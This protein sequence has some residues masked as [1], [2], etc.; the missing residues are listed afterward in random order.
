MISMIRLVLALGFVGA[1]TYAQ[2]DVELATARMVGASQVAPVFFDPGKN[3]LS[4]EEKKELRTFFTSLRESEK[5][6]SVRVLSWGD[7][8][9]PAKDKKVSSKQIS[10][11][12]DRA[13][14]IKKFLKQDLKIDSVDTHNMSERPSK[15]SELFKTDENEVKSSAEAT[16]AAPAQNKTGVFEEMARSTTALVLVVLE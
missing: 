2:P 11:A 16:G 6:K 13:E 15:L 7:R 10:L 14:A 3:S 9:Y 4:N 12:Q 8:E 1:I 5:I